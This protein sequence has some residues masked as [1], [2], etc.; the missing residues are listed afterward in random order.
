MR[1]IGKD[2]D[3]CKS[4]GGENSRVIQRIRCLRVRV[5]ISFQI[6]S[7]LNRPNLPISFPSYASREMSRLSNAVPL[8][9]ITCIGA[10]TSTFC[11]L[12]TIPG[13]YSTPLLTLRYPGFYTFNPYLKE[14]AQSRQ[15]TEARERDVPAPTQSQTPMKAS[16][17]PSLSS[18]SKES[19]QA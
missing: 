9:L 16:E 18:G 6:L 14:D 1:R 10:A 8:I 19:K 15:Q 5:W 17:K 11:P 4:V 13:A 7:Y 12:P 3:E 2:V